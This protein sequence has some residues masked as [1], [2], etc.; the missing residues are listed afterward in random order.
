MTSGSVAYY[1]FP[2]DGGA[3]LTRIVAKLPTADRMAATWRPT[4][5]WLLEVSARLAQALPGL[6]EEAGVRRLDPA[7]KPGAVLV[8]HGVRPAI[9]AV[10]S[11]AGRSG[12]WS[13]VEGVEFATARSQRAFEAA[14]DPTRSWRPDV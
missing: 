1:P 3:T 4:E 6:F 9:E 12:K 7:W 8:P 14:L 11:A 2:D 10:L 5:N 13:S